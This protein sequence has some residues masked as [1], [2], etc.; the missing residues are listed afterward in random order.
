M[1]TPTRFRGGEAKSEHDSRR[2]K[3]LKEGNEDVEVEGG[4]HRSLPQQDGEIW[5]LQ[6]GV[7]LHEIITLNLSKE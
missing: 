4:A 7:C 1:V 5:Q 6:N 3:F 2:A